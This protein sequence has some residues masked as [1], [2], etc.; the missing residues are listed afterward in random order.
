ME[1]RV[2]HSRCGCLSKIRLYTYLDSPFLTEESPTDP[3]DDLYAP[4]MSEDGLF[5]FI[6][7][8][9]FYME[10]KKHSE[11]EIA[12]ALSSASF[13]VGLIQTGVDSYENFNFTPAQLKEWL[14]VKS[15]NVPASGADTLQIIDPRLVGREVT[16]VG[17]GGGFHNDVFAPKALNSD[18]LV[19]INP[20]PPDSVITVNLA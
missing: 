4:F 7:E 19:F 5:L 6:P 11:T 2:I 17:Y 16:S 1:Y 13:F 15:F 8:K 14:G 3:E 12:A 20:V 18:T 9:P 10:A